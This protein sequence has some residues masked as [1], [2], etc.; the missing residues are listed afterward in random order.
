MTSSSRPFRHTVLLTHAC[1]AAVS[2]V[3]LA[4]AY[5]PYQEAMLRL[6]SWV[7]ASTRNLA[8]FVAV[9]FGIPVLL[10]LL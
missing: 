4:L 7:T 6:V 9:L 10:V 1:V 3:I 8:W 5:R 2:V